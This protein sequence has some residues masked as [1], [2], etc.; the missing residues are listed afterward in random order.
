MP[1]WPSPN[2]RAFSSAGTATAQAS[3]IWP[4]IASS[5]L[6]AGG[7]PG[8]AGHPWRHRASPAPRPPVWAP[9]RVA[10][11]VPTSQKLGGRRG[12]HAS[13]PARSRLPNLRAGSACW[14]PIPAPSRHGRARRRHRAPRAAV[15]RP[16]QAALPR[17]P[18]TGRYAAARLLRQCAPVPRRLRLRQ[19][20]HAPLQHQP[21]RRP[22]GRRTPRGHS[23]ALPRDGHR[24][25]RGASA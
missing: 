18:W 6:S 12:G 10:L 9:S 24:G 7:R 20:G 8:G 17:R 3:S 11:R 14:R 5:T 13:A 19:R 21:P 22:E 1:P 15:A 4:S 23:R 2:S 25:D 16:R